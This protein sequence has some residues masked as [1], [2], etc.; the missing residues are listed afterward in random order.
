MNVYTIYGFLTTSKPV[1]FFIELLHNVGMHVCVY[2]YLL[3]RL[4]ITSGVM[5][6]N[7]DPYDWLNEFYGF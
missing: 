2:M 5:G 1:T 6:C 7:I 3:S 4:L